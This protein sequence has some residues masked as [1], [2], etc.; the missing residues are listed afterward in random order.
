MVIAV[1]ARRGLAPD[2]EAGR[3]LPA[4]H[5]CDAARDRTLLGAARGGDR[6]ARGRLFDCYLG[7]VRAI[8]SQYRDYGL[9]F[10][11]LVQEGSIG[12]LDAIDHYDP[13]RGASFDAYARFR[14]RRAIRNGLS[15]QARLIRLPR[16]VV[17]KRRA[18]D[19]AEA[20]MVTSGQ[21]PTPADLAAATGLSLAAVL[22]ARS[23][24]EAPLSLDEPFLPDGSTLE[25]LIADPAAT[26]PAVA[27]VA[28]DQS[29]RLGRALAQ[30]P[31]RQRRVITARW[32][33]EGASV[34]S[35]TELARTLQ[36]SPRRT[37]TI[38]N[39]A[40]FELRKSLEPGVPPARSALSLATQE[41]NR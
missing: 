20:R 7:I 2:S 1:Q 27:T 22:E 19:R 17:Q 36:L 9:P 14:V 24:T 34:P 16:Q 10:D 13:G 11:D 5:R 15:D 3:R 8:A 35:A 41:A 29:E 31:E 32:G 28:N 18:L 38:G 4:R 6:A 33:L 30:L 12:L 40:L 25:S 39:D 37:Q 21:Q 26:D 23:V